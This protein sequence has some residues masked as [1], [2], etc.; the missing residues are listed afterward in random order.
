MY[1]TP[2]EVVG[3]SEVMGFSRANGCPTTLF[4]VPVVETL[5]LTDLDDAMNQFAAEG[6]TQSF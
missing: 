5:K 1:T 6:N 4:E 3:N 2:S